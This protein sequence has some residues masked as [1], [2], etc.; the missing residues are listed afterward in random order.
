[1]ES[2]LVANSGLQVLVAER[3]AATIGVSVAEVCSVT[4][5]TASR[6]F[7][8]PALASLR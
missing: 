3:L 8:L 5:A 1:M 4:T 6:F 7:G 2:D